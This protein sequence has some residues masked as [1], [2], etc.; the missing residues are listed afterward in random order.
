MDNLYKNLK[1]ADIL[2]LATPVYI[3]LLVKIQNFMNRLCPLLNPDLVIREGRTRA[4]LQDDVKIGKAVL[5]STCGWW[6]MGNFRTVVRIL[7]EFCE[8][9]SIRFA[10]ALL[11]PHFDYM[12]HNEDK[13]EEVLE[14]SR[15]AGQQLIRGGGDSSRRSK[16]YQP[17]TDFP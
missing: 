5:A 4:R 2:V 8:D 7:E 11:R 12:R 10:G 16:G 13:R 1:K 14:A 3:P 6:E 15:D 9:A 17:T